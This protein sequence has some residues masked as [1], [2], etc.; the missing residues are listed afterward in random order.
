MSLNQ[1]HDL[2][3]RLL[4]NMNLPELLKT[5]QTNHRMNSICEDNYF[6]RRKI[7]HDY[8]KEIVAMKPTRETYK[9]Q[10]VRIYNTIKQP[11]YLRTQMP[12]DTTIALEKMGVVPNKWNAHYAAMFGDIPKLEWLEQRKILP[13]SN[14]ARYA[15]QQGHVDTL[16][17]LAARGI[18]PGDDAWYKIL[19]GRN[20]KA[21]IRWL[22][23]EG[24]REYPEL[25]ASDE[26][27][28]VQFEP[29][30]YNWAAERDLETLQW[31]LLISGEPL[32][33]EVANAAVI[34]NNLEIL[35]WL[36]EQR[37][38]PA[39][40]AVDE[41]IENEAWSVLGWLTQYRI[42]PNIE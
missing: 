12:L 38:F 25:F 29:V 23:V 20:T 15:A 10:Y 7:I 27:E 13:S 8:G 14:D 39:Q 2:D 22:L 30:L 35:E 40:W 26:A 3:F 42:Y 37:I 17:W 18:L 16:R 24:P 28:F 33:E 5:C 36:T 32:T 34:H 6:W 21:V 31:L 11:D 41:A 4:L 1:L 9:E 19:D